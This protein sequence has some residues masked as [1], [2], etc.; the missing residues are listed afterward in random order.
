MYFKDVYQ[1]PEINNA[2]NVLVQAEVIHGMHCKDPFNWPST[3]DDNFISYCIEKGPAFFQ[4]DN[5]SFEKSAR[6]KGEYGK[7]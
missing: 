3:I 4:N 6:R 2:K 5:C 1:E 7:L